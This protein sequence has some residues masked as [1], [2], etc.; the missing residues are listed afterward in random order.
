MLRGGRWER[1]ETPLVHDASLTPSEEER[2]WLRQKLSRL[3]CRPRR[4]QKSL[5]A[6]QSQQS[7]ESCPYRVQSG[8][9][10]WKPGF[11]TH[12]RMNFWG[13]SSV[14]LCVVGGLPLKVHKCLSSSIQLLPRILKGPALNVSSSSKLFLEWNS[15]HVTWWFHSLQW[16]SPNLCLVNS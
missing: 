9:A 5:W 10:Q 11:S 15:Q 3:L 6:V 14:V 4:V 13:S 2:D 12:V 8:A 7:L 1:W 16:S